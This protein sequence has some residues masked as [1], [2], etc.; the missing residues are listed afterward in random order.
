MTGAQRLILELAGAIASTPG[1][2]HCVTLLT[3]TVS[4]ACRAAIPAGVRLCESG[5]N[6]NRTPNHYLNSLLEYF[7]TPFLLRQLS[8]IERESGEKISALC[9]F[10]P[11]SLPG[12]WWGKHL[13]RLKMPLFYFC[14]EPPRAAYTDIGEVSRAWAGRVS[15]LVKP[16]FRL[17]RPI[18]RYLA[19]QA[20]AALVNGCYGQSLI[21]ETYGL[22]SIVI[23]HGA[24]LTK[25]SDPA[26]SANQIRARFGLEGKRV[27]LTVNHL[28][29]RKRVNLQ[30][31][32]LSLLLPKYPDVALLVVG[33]G[34]EAQNLRELAGRLGIGD[35]VVFAGFVPDEELAACYSV[36]AVYLHS[37]RAESF[38]LSV[39]EASAA[40]LPVVAADEGGPRD[41]ILEGQTGF[42]VEA[43][44]AAFG[45]TLEWL[46]THPTEAQ[47]I[48]RRGAARVAQHF[49][50]QQGAQDFLSA[51]STLSPE[52]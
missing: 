32:A 35:S 44:P 6:L 46:L 14:Y 29:P 39:L 50:W 27:I 13:H 34:P 3:H 45:A 23:T 11:P 16:F 41:I 40:G 17:Y 5:F 4:P 7:S 33:S 19:R 24:E 52:K 10:G 48:G 21:R 2:S 8:H 28:H 18:D 38:G 37:G 12:L 49:T 26:E 20:S 25:S 1:S 30:L 22:P 31:E 51:L 43:N 15:G 47:E 9:F 36:A 42:L